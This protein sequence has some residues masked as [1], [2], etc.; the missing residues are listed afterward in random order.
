[1]QSAASQRIAG[2]GRIVELA[3][4]RPQ[5]ERLPGRSRDTVFRD[6]AVGIGEGTVFGTVTGPDRGGRDGCQDAGRPSLAARRYS[7][8]SSFVW[9][10]TS[11]T[12]RRLR[13]EGVTPRSDCHFVICASVVA[14]AP[15]AG[16]R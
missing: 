1:M 8:S 16:F 9:A 11:A 7:S 14:S 12:P 4:P 6:D 5:S 15:W 10:F 3:L 2:E 13:S